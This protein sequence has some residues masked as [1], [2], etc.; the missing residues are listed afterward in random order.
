ML[1]L[2]LEPSSIC[3]HRILLQTLFV[4]LLL[5]SGSFTFVFDIF[6]LFRLMLTISKTLPSL[7]N[8]LQL[9]QEYGNQ[10]TPGTVATIFLPKVTT[11]RAVI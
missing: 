6:S 11:A 1:L 8:R 10:Q 5:F 4:S 3:N 7:G 9:P 2:Q